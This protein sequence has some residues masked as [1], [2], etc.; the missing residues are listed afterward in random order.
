[1]KH[2]ANLQWYAFRYDINCNSLVEFNVVNDDLIKGIEKACKKKE[3]ETIDDLWRIVRRWAVYYY[4]SKAE[5]EVIITD[6]FENMRVK[7]DVYYQIEINMERFV[8]YIN[9]EMQLEL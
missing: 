1:M 7:K 5:H 3:L 9:K 6:L 4:W 2:K 8:D